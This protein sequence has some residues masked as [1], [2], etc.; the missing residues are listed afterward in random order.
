MDAWWDTLA[1]APYGGA[2]GDLYAASHVERSDTPRGHGGSAFITPSLLSLVQKDLRSVLGEKV[3]GPLSTSYCGNGDLAACRAALWESLLAT[4]RLLESPK[5][6][7]SANPVEATNHFGS[8]EVAAWKRTVADDEIQF[9]GVLSK[10]V[11]MTWQNRP[12]FQ[13]VVELETSGRS[14]KA[15]SAPTSTTTSAATK[16]SSSS[17]ETRPAWQLAAL[18][19]GAVAIMG[20]TLRSLRRR[21]VK[22]DS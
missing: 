6:T 1:K 7:A 16:K 22:S 10:A 20:G 8:P 2:L 9:S 18:A 5:P 21:K 13:Q 17:D 11:P 4:V 15:A 14:D 19:V 3:A 12:T